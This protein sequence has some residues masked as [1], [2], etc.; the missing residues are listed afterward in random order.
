MPSLILPKMQLNS[1][2]VRFAVLIYVLIK[3]YGCGSNQVS[4]QFCWASYLELYLTIIQLW[5][6]IETA[7][8]CS[9]LLKSIYIIHKLL[10]IRIDGIQGRR[11]KGQGATAPKGFKEGKHKEIWTSWGY[12]HATKLSKLKLLKISVIF[13]KEIH[14]L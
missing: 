8:K 14:T 7:L 4:T 2:A 10:L 11:H 12:F 3:F 9:T 13:I 6:N 1:I 5:C